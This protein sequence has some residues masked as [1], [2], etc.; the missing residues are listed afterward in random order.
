MNEE[1]IKHSHSHKFLMSESY[2]VGQVMC[3]DVR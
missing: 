3:S 2:S 1:K